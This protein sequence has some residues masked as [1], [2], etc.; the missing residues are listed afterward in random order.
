ML[1]IIWGGISLPG[2]R[3]PPW[4][5]LRELVS[6]F[7]SL[8]DGVFR[9]LEQNVHRKLCGFLIG[10]FHAL[11]FGIRDFRST[12][13]P[14]RVCDENPAAGWLVSSGMMS[15]EPSPQA[16]DVM[17]HEILATE[18]P[19]GDGKRATNWVVP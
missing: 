1:H 13:L 6:Q 18:S 9:I 19:I 7:E 15:H 8:D 3:L 14:P 12:L 10:G 17:F 2:F 5:E 16:A 4:R 11:H